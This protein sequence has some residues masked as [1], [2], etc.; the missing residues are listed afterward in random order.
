VISYSQASIY[1]AKLEDYVLK[2]HGQGWYDLYIQVPNLSAMNTW[3]SCFNQSRPDYLD[4]RR[5]PDVS[6]IVD[7][8]HQQDEVLPHPLFETSLLQLGDDLSEER[9]SESSDKTH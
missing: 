9:V 7:E 5:K 6:T 8:N 2:I 4:F 1:S 3:Q